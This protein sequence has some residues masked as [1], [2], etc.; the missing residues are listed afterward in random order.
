[1]IKV[2]GQMLAWAR[3]D[4]GL[5]VADAAPLLGYNDATKM[6]AAEKLM[7]AEHTGE[8]SKTVLT[9]IQTVYRKPLLTYYL[10]KPPRPVDVGEDFRTPSNI[11]DPQQDRI[12]K[13]ILSNVSARQSMIR[14]LLIAEDEV[15]ALDFIGAID[16]NMSPE[17]AATKIRDLFDISLDKY[18]KG[19]DYAASFK[20]LRKK[21]EAKGVF[22]LLKGNLGNYRSDV[23]VGTFRGFAISDDIAPFIVINHQEAKSARAFTLLHELTHILL[24][25]TGI[26]AGVSEHEI[27]QFCDR[28]ASLTLLPDTELRRFTITSDT[29]IEL[30]QSISEF[31]LTKKVS[32]SQLAY[33]L[34]LLDKLSNDTYQKLSTFF[35]EQWLQSKQRGK[36]IDGNGP[37]ANVVKKNYLGGIVN[38]VNRMFDAGAISSTQAGIVLDTHPTRVTKLFNNTATN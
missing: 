38:F 15:Q 9:K 1:V 19:S 3:E 12:V 8:V 23:E 17:K 6:S 24:G 10:E 16:M 7:H 2:N 36:S 4:C 13:A 29:F 32:S 22:V 5:S 21:I 33:R 30:A 35:H 18:R 28:T 25:K 11:G 37:D 31:A 27:E 20:Y 34:L 26:S 14:E